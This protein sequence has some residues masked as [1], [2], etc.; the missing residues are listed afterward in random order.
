MPAADL[1]CLSAVSVLVACSNLVH[2]SIT[3]RDWDDRWRDATIHQCT[4]LQSLH[5]RSRFVS[6]LPLSMAWSRLR[7]VNVSNCKYV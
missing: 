6:T 4:H 1:Q 3:E 5:L 7:E 2:L